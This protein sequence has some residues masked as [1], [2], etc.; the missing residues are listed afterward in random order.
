[1]VFPTFLCH[2]SMHCWKESS[3]MSFNYV[4]TVLLRDF[5][6]SKRLPLMILDEFVKKKKSYLNCRILWGL[7]VG[8]FTWWS[9][10]DLSCHYFRLFPYSEQSIRRRISSLICWLIVWPCGKN[11]FWRCPSYKRT[12]STYFWLLNWTICGPRDVGDF[13]WLFWCLAKR[14]HSKIHVSSP[15]KFGS[16]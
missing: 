3:G 15:S 9:S 8:A 4:V 7:W 14:S 6:A 1:M 12:W 5:T 2:V 16:V 10:H 13:H 11:L